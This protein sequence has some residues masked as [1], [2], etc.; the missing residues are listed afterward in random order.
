MLS[1]TQIWKIVSKKYCPKKILLGKKSVRNKYCPKKFCPKFF[2]P[3]IK[4]SPKIILSKNILSEKN[5]GLKM[6]TPGKTLPHNPL[7]KD[8]T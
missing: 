7:L 2:L 3:G 4:Y 1:N 5:V 8:K 6:H